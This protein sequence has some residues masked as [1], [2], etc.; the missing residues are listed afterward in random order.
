MRVRDAGDEQRGDGEQRNVARSRGRAGGQLHAWVDRPV[1]RWFEVLPHPR[2]A[3][4]ERR[5]H[6]AM[7]HRV[8][9]VHEVLVRGPPVGEEVRHLHQHLQVQR[10]RGRAER[11]LQGLP[12]DP[13]LDSF[14]VRAE[15]HQRRGGGQAQVHVVQEAGSE[16]PP[17][18]S[19]HR[20]E[21][22]ADV[23]VDEQRGRGLLGFLACEVR[24]LGIRPVQSHQRRVR[25]QLVPEDAPGTLPSS[26]RQRGMHQLCPVGGGLPV[27]WGDSLLRKHVERIGGLPVFLFSTIS[28]I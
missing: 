21:R 18:E 12:G 26:V 19:G 20:F 23:R 15:V 16:E 14:A 11:G 25:R 6:P 4:P 17:R 5:L 24:D 10:M 2:V 27:W 8:G 28:I 1:D 3:A 13:G 9:F 7:E 22:E